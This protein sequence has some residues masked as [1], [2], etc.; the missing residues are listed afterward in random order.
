MQMHYC[1]TILLALIQR[2]N[3]AVCL[4]ICNYKLL[5]VHEWKYL[6]GKNP[7]TYVLVDY[8]FPSIRYF[9]EHFKSVQ[10]LLWTFA[11]SGTNKG[12]LR[13]RVWYV[14]SPQSRLASIT[15]IIAS[16]KW[17]RWKC[18]KSYEC[19]IYESE[20]QNVGVLWYAGH[21]WCRECELRRYN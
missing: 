10:K 6:K 18:R 9:Q 7:T 19:R 17:W 11:N 15:K 4:G 14:T 3:V 13:F 16:V 5:G 21:M 20:I 2:E 1:L 8:K 12:A